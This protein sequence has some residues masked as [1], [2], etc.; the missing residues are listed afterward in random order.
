MALK[1]RRQLKA[2]EF[3]IDAAYAQWRAGQ[4]REALSKLAQ[5][6]KEMEQLSRT[7]KSTEFHTSW[8]VMEHIAVWFKCDAGAPHNLEIINPR[9]GICSEAKSEEKHDL[10]KDAPRAHVLV[11]WYCLAEAELYAGL[12]REIFR[13]IAARNDVKSYPNLRPIFDFL[14]ARRALADREF[15][16]I[17]VFAESS[18]LAISQIDVKSVT[19]QTLFQQSNPIT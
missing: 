6:L 15:K 9:P 17:P 8:K 18:S 10:V 3:G 16:L 4:K 14:R 1:V 12:G 7:D 13:M 2:L 19:E 11:S 5:C